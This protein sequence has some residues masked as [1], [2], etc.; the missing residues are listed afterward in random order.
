R[1]LSAH[2]SAETAAISGQL[3]KQA[4]SRWSE[5]ISIAAGASKPFHPVCNQLTVPRIPALPFYERSAFGWAAG[6]EA[7]TDRIRGELERVLREGAGDLQPYINM[8]DGAPVDQ[9]REL[10]RSRKW[11]TY[12]LW[13]HGEPVTANLKK[14]PETA[15]ALAEADLASIDGLCP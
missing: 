10:N 14:C 15:M 5:A 3:S 11:S 8:P 7:R 6:I 13:R 12:P 9:W 2:L 4:G 1:R